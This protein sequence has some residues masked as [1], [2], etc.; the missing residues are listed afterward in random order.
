MTVAPLRFAF[1]TNGAANHRLHDAV[2][3]IAFADR[4]RRLKARW[5]LV[6]ASVL[7]LVA[8]PVTLPPSWHE[9]VSA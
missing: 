6:G 9:P 8:L 3:L 4:F 5:L 2:A 1:N 7:P